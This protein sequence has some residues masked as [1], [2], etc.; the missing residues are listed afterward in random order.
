MRLISI[1]VMLV[2]ASIVYA[3]GVDEFLAREGGVRAILKNYDASFVTDFDDY[4]SEFLYGV[5]K[6]EGFVFQLSAKAVG[7]CVREIIEIQDGFYCFQIE[8]N[9]G[10]GGKP[11]MIALIIGID[12]QLALLRAMAIQGNGFEISNEEIVRCFERWS[13]EFSFVVTGVGIDFIQA[14]IIARPNSFLK[15]AR[16]IYEMC[17]DVVD[18]G[19]GSV[20]ALASEL[21]RTN[22]MFFWWD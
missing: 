16:E 21:R 2:L 18:Q 12:D 6:R 7:T 20:I 11:D 8:Q 17:P 19:A 10:V 1:A 4:A 22:A 14:D 3:E 13:S 15:L 5:E 9:F